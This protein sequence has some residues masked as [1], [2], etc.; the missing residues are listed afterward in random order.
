MA[1][2]GT[3]DEIGRLRNEFIA[4][5]EFMNIQGTQVDR[6][7]VRFHARYGIILLAL[8][9]TACS[10]TLVGVAPT[11]PM[12]AKGSSVATTS[13]SSTAKGA[14]PAA[15]A[16]GVASA[17]AKG[18][19]ESGPQSKALNL[20]DAIA[21]DSE[22]SGSSVG[23]DTLSG[24]S[25]A[26]DAAAAGQGGA[27]GKGAAVAGAAAAGSAAGA[28]SK[29]APAGAG[30]TSAAAGAGS[31]G[32]AAGAGTTS[33]A[34]GAAAKPGSAAA[35]DASGKSAAAAGAAGAA[36]G[37]SGGSST[38]GNGNAG[39]G[40]ASGTAKSGAGTDGAADYGQVAA[41]AGSAEDAERRAQRESDER[42]AALEAE[43]RGRVETA[44]NR[45]VIDQDEKLQT[46]GGTLPATFNMDERGQFEF[47]RYELSAETKMKLDEI[48]HKLNEAPYD[49]IIVHGYTDRIGTDEYNQQLSEKRAW[50][51]AGYLMDKGVPPYKLTVVGR[52]KIAPLTT[53]EECKGLKRD[54]L[55]DCLQRDRRVEVVATL[56]E[57]N[58]KVQ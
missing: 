23:S 1:A 10:G 56:K 26:D 38:G 32:A 14:E 47:D 45:V 29:G 12:P 19:A 43:R 30:S 54:A 41:A 46:L 40:A 48:A 55:I 31:K 35:G 53:P 33:G 44:A 49:R 27:A 52:G 21:V 51:V 58:L 18:S 28:D 4:G 34:D 3:D 15:G 8:G 39:A 11:K 24:K 37:K 5:G 36:A 6:P 25:A 9:M 57:Y 13:T 50:A 16:G 42:T 17:G 7:S 2:S 22:E 20:G